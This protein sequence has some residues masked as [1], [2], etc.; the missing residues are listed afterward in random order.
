[1][2]HTSAYDTWKKMTNNFVCKY[3]SLDDFEYFVDIIVNQK[4]YVA[5]YTTLNDPMEGHY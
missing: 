3:R 4:L 1:M 2:E 5:E